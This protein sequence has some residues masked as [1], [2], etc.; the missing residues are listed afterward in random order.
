MTRRFNWA[1]ARKYH[2]YEAIGRQKRLSKDEQAF[3]VDE[4]EITRRRAVAAR[5]KA[6]E[7]A[8]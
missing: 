3:L 2:G 6:I 7:R 8:H 5:R 4:D 1:K